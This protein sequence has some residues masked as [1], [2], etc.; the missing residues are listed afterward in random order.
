M[1]TG[2]ATKSAEKAGYGK[3]GSTVTRLLDNPLVQKYI[4]DELEKIYNPKIADANEVIEYLTEVMRGEHTEE[5]LRLVGDGIQE[6][7]EM[8]VS[9]KERLK[10]SQLLGKRYGI[11]REKV[12]IK[13]DVPIVI[14]G[15]ELL[16]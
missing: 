4:D 15:A 9:E 3:S 16:E 13:S 14:S 12:D 11:F 8:R 2:N 5:A 6:K 7:I 1:A 10:A